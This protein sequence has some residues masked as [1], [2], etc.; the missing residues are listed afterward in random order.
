M[1]F[2]V[3][4]PARYESTRL[5]GK[6]LI[7]FDG[8]PM[9]VRVAERAVASGAMRV[10]IATDDKRVVDAVSEHH[11]EVIMTSPN[12]ISG[13]DRIAEVAALANF[14]DS[15]IIVNVQGDEPLMPPPLI[16][17][18]AETLAMSDVAMATACHT[19][20]DPIEITNPNIVKVVLDINKDALYFSRAII[21]WA[22]DA[23]ANGI[24]SIP[25]GLPIY[26]H[27]GIYAYRV[28]FLKK[29][30]QLSPA[31]IEQFESLEQL[32]ALWHGEKIRVFVVPSAPPGGVDT[33]EDVERVQKEFDRLRKSG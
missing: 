2:T 26:R 29:F 1:T 7:K 25:T 12:H 9:V 6:P 15:E 22:R 19:L 4:I 24:L 3:V 14:S 23:F 10:V 13:T 27:I 20:T 30:C 11:F 18:V 8:K 17:S 21:P 5:P 31:P 33:P 28:G 16:R 32:R